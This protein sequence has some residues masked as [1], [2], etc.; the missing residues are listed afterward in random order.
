MQPPAIHR[1]AVDKGGSL[2]ERLGRKATSSP[3]M[4][5]SYIVYLLPF[6]RALQYGEFS[7]VVICSLA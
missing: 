4:F 2:I 5:D 3:F 6:A 1:R 7:T